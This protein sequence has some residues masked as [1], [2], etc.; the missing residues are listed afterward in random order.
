MHRRRRSKVRMKIQI[1]TSD[2][3]VNLPLEMMKFLLV[4]KVAL[5]YRNF[6]MRTPK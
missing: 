5:I 6:L 4:A 1:I 3:K 2:K